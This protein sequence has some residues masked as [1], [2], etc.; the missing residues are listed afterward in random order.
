MNIILLG[1]PG[2]GKGTQAQ[3]LEQ[4]FMIP[5]ISTG[6]IFRA[7]I[8]QKTEIG[9]KAEKYISKGKLVPDT[10]TIEIVKDRLAME[11][12]AKGF[13]LD[14]FPRTK[15]QAEALDKILDQLGKQI[16]KV[17]NIEIQDDLVI[18]RLSKRRVCPG[19]GASYHLEDHPSKIAGICDEC[20]TEII[21][22]KDDIKETI[23]NRLHIYH[24]ETTSLI[25]YYIEQNKLFTIVN[26]DTVEATTQRMMEIF[27]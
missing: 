26:D 13:I 6:D 2:A 21:Q 10:I 7:H 17:I 27:S 11:D 1:A 5:Q 20:K 25:K 12:C 19:C 24:K 16:D 23:L 15:N 9:R 3:K 18:E 4:R 22:R 14:G 8:S